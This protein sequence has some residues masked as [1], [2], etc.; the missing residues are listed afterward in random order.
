LSGRRAQ[1]IAEIGQAMQ[2]QQGQGTI[3]ANA[4]ADR[5]D[6]TPTELECLGMLESRGPLPAGELAKRTGLTSGAV[7]RL[8]DRLEAR[9]I[10]R[11]LSDRED[12]RRVLV[13]MTPM[14]RRAAI[15]FYEPIARE[16]AEMLSAYSEKDLELILDFARRSYA[17]GVKHT[18]RV[19][20]MPRRLQSRRVVN[21]KGRILG[22]KVRIRI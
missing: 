19:E 22:Q 12:R 2:E 16:G 9:G 17:F 20:A 1:L 7:T 8:I 5:L 4:I 6:V 11:R 21:F 10:V 15:P 18:E 13:E 3:L 14:A